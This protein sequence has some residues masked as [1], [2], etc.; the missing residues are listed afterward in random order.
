[1]IKHP[2]SPFLPASAPSP[3]PSLHIRAA[4]HHGA[5]DAP[6][7]LAGL[8]EPVVAATFGV[9][10]A[11]LARGARV[12]VRMVQATVA[13]VATRHFTVLLNKI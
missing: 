4:V 13:R 11:V 5:A 1:M 12:T 10:Q 3:S 2:F 6:A 9:V 8:P 7:E